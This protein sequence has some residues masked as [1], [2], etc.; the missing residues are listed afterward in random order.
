MK[1]LTDRGEG[2]LRRF[3][4]EV[5]ELVDAAPL[6]RG[7]R[8][9]Q[10]DRAAEAGIAVD[11][12][13]HRRAQPARREVVE[14]AL[15]RCERLAGA[16]LEGQELLAPVGQHADHTEHGR[17]HDLA[18]AA[19]AQG[20]AIKVEKERVDIA[21]GACPPRRQP[22]LERRDDPRYCALRQR[23]GLEQGL[24]R[25]AD[26]PRVAA[27]QVRRGDRFIHLGQSPLVPWQRSDVHSRPPNSVARGTVSAR[28]PLGPVRVRVRA[29]LR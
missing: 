4:L 28:G 10:A 16:E 29:P 17:A 26:P 2:M 25:A 15:P 8:P 21:E 6:H 14:A 24:E 9:H 18:G 20:K 22:V 19:H 1:V 23:R 7:P 11:D 12:A 5:A 13:E 27:G 3:P